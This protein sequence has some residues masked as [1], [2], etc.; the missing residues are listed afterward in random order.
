MIGLAD[1][2]KPGRSTQRPANDKLRAIGPRFARRPPNNGHVALNARAR[3]RKFSHAQ[4][5]AYPH[6]SLIIADP[7]D[8][9]PVKGG[10]V[11]HVVAG[12]REGG[13]VVDQP[14]IVRLGVSDHDEGAAEKVGGEYEDEEGVEDADEGY[15]VLRH[16][17]EGAVLSFVSC[18]FCVFFVCTVNGF[19]PSESVYS[20][21]QLLCGLLRC[22]PVFRY[23]TCPLVDLGSS[24]RG[25]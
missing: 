11:A 25:F 6:S 10:D 12:E 1:H 18:L 7:P 3:F 4:P 20:D 9:G 22:L 24:K 16:R 5:T 8:H 19:P 15:E 23:I 13:L 2:N 14:V 21:S 17:R